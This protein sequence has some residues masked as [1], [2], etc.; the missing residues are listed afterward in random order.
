MPKLYTIKKVNKPQKLKNRSDRELKRIAHDIYT[1]KVFCNRQVE[2]SMLSSVFMVWA[3]LNPLEKKEMLDRG[4]SMMYAEMSNAMP[5]QINGYPVFG[6]MSVL[7]KH[8]DHMV[9]KHYK[10]IQEAMGQYRGDFYYDQ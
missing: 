5:R 8:D 10:D 4:M 3:L 6:E 1:G 7:N 9:Y 2:P